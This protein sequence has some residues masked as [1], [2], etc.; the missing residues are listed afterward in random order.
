[1][2][3]VLVNE[4]SLNGIAAAIREKNGETTKYKPSEMAAAITALVIGGGGSGE[5]DEGIPFEWGSDLNYWNYSGMWDWYFEKYGNKIT[6]KYITNLNNAF[7]WSELTELP[8]VLNGGSEYQGVGCSNA[9]AYAAFMPT[10]ENLAGIQN[11]ISSPS[12]MFYNNRSFD[13]VPELYMMATKDNSYEYMFSQLNASEIGT[14]HNAYM[15]DT[16]YMFYRSQKLRHAPK[17]E[18]ARMN[19]D[20]LGSMKHTGFMF[21]E[22]Y[23]LRDIPEDFLKIIYNEKGGSSYT[24]F[25]SQFE[26]CYVLDEVVGIN[27]RTKAMT[28]NIFATTFKNCHRLKNIVFAKKEDGTPYTVSWKNQTIDLHDNIGWDDQS[29][30]NGAYVVAEGKLERIVRYNSG[31]TSDKYVNDGATYAALKDDPD[32]FTNK[33]EYSRYNHTSAVKTINSLPDAS[34]YL[35]TQSSGTNIIKFR[36]DA[37]MSTDGGSI[38]NLTEEEIAVAT[39]KGWNVVYAV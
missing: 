27:P 33:Y 31:I 24:H 5:G 20:G 25:N 13:S 4:T 3:K 28:S 18:N 14:I 17:F 21:K 38:G 16:G 10:K 26:D 23:S 9:F 11:Y 29:Q 30:S 12:Y 8:I 35:A 19:N 1:M 7:Y 22:C 6:T 36:Q 34:T 32:W 37:G 15:L 39:A 2:S